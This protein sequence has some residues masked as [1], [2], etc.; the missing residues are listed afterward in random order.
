M[1]DRGS[2]PRCMILSSIENPGMRKVWWDVQIAILGHWFFV[3]RDHRIDGG[4][5][6]H[7][8]HQRIRIHEGC[9]TG[10]AS[11]RSQRIVL[12]SEGANAFESSGEKICAGRVP[13]IGTNSGRDSSAIIVRFV[14]PVQAPR[15]PQTLLTGI[16]ESELL[17]PDRVRVSPFVLYPGSS[18]A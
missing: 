9:E 11:R 3:P 18:E 8:E 14:S 10:H 4:R 15:T 7:L 5:M 1:R 6:R 16:T 2:I 12:S 13:K 17:R